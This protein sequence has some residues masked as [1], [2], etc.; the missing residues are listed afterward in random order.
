MQRR[1][2]PPD[3]RKAGVAAPHDFADHRVVSVEI[4]S[5]AIH[6]RFADDKVAPSPGKMFTLRPSI[7]SYDT[8]YPKIT[9]VCGYAEADPDKVTGGIN[10]T[11]IERKYLPE[12]CR[13]P[14]PEN[15]AR[16]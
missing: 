16:L 15:M 5:G 7:E 11:T 13:G 4:E 12:N 3:N 9:W 2:F 8:S 14:E 10:R 6:V 1:E